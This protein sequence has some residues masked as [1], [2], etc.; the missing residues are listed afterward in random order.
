ME[1]KS[2]FII[3][4]SMDYINSVSRRVAEE[5]NMIIKD[6]ALDGKQALQ[7]L[8]KYNDI[9]VLIVD[10]VTPVYDGYRVLKEIKENKML[11][12][13]INF[14]ICQS[15]II[16]DNLL[17][18]LSSYGCDLFLLKPYSIEVLIDHINNAS[19]KREKVSTK[20]QV[21]EKKITKVLHEVGIPAHIKGYEYLRT[22]INSSYENPEYFSQITKILYP[23]IAKKYKTTGSRV[24]RAIRHAIEVA[25]NRGNID[26][27][28]EIFGYT[29]SASKA[30]PT[31][32]E[33]I[34][35][36]SDYIKMN[37][38]MIDAKLKI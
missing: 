18:L 23:E 26:A 1:K 10:L 4:D 34:A 27:I 29:I 19:D 31:N 32:S 14:I 21:I 3:D 22:A 9:D 17:A 37:N 13:N 5:E 33:F 12:P 24:E 7:K 15:G 36:I 16:N 6:Y 20:E 28:D 2:I 38:N 25:W 35:M 8:Q 30:K 11:Y